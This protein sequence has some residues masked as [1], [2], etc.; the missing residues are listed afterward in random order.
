M[1]SGPTSEGSPAVEQFVGGGAAV[2]EASTKAFR[3]SKADARSTN[4]S[5]AKYRTSIVTNVATFNLLP[6]EAQNLHQPGYLS[7][8]ATHVPANG[9]WL[10]HTVTLATRSH[11]SVIVT[12]NPGPP[13]L[14]L[15]RLVRLVRLPHRVRHRE[16]LSI[17]QQHR[18]ARRRELD[19]RRPERSICDSDTVKNQH[20]ALLSSHAQRC[21]RLGIPT[22]STFAA[23]PS[24][25]SR[26]IAK[27]FVPLTITSISAA[28]AASGCHVKLRQALVRMITLCRRGWKADRGAV[29]KE[30]MKI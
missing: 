20:V 14:A 11:A 5:T 13:A 30:K 18:I 25:G 23:A 7:S 4:L 6:T 24:S 8:G 3:Q 22:A 27:P 2:F 9:S 21:L 16:H 29:R 15:V 10:G 26:H 28:R 17:L 1:S 19:R 12:T